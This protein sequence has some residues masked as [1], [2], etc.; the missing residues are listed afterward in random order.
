M[1]KCAIINPRAN[2]GTPTYPGNKNFML[3][4]AVPR[5]LTGTNLAVHIGRWFS[6]LLS[7]GT[8]W[9]TFGIARLAFPRSPTL[10]LL[11]MITVA[12]IPQFAFIGASVSNDPLII[13]VA[14]ATL[15]WMLVLL[16]RDST[17]PIAIK[18]WTILGLLLALA[19]IS[20][21]QGLS[22]YVLAAVVVPLLCW[23]RRDWRLF[24][25]A[26]LI[27]GISFGLIAGWWYWRNYLLYGDFFA[28]GQLLEI[29]GLRTE[30]QTWAGFWGELRGLRYSFWGLFGWFSILLPV[31]IY[32]ILDA[33]TVLAVV[34]VGLWTM[35]AV[36]RDTIE[37][38]LG[39][40]QVRVWLGLLTFAA[41]L[42]GLML[43]WLTFAISSQGRLL[44][45]GISAY[46]V[47]LVGG[48]YYLL[49]RVKLPRPV[50]VLIMLPLLLIGGSVYALTV[51]LPASYAASAPVITMPSTAKP[52]GKI[53]GDALEL[54]AVDLPTRRFRA[55]EDVPIT[56]YLRAL[57]PQ[58][59]N[60]ELFVQL[61]NQEN[62]VVGNI[63][64]QPGWGRN[65]TS[66]WQLDA[67]YAD[68]YAVTAGSNISNRSPLLA[69]VY[70]G[71]VEEVT[72]D[73]L[74]VQGDEAAPN[75]R[76]VGTVQFD[77]SG[78]QDPKLLLLDEINTR[79]SQMDG[80]VIHLTGY[81]VPTQPISDSRQPLIVTLFWQALG[82]PDADY[83][84]F[85]H[86]IDGDGN[87]VAGF[88]QPPAEG[89]FP[90]S[91]WRPGD[92]SLS[93]FTL[94]LPSDLAP[95]S[96]ELWAGL[97][98]PASPALDRLP[99][100]ASDQP[101]RDHRVRLGTIVLQ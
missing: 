26:G 100:T 94:I 41:I 67:I 47:M 72:G 10:A 36:R 81:G 32:L 35:Q 2:L 24:V 54:V 68:T 82:T 53:Y 50:S 19:A 80:E 30:S 27:L 86:L 70:V 56:L 6:L 101:V 65:P 61:L 55:G 9:F 88:D 34:G 76:T 52:V 46:G 99:I 20:K 25:Q 5:P 13:L 69:K 97:Y 43:Y 66:L 11:A 44:F 17:D 75:N 22:L 79:F 16:Q 23:Q 64:T 29:N 37:N 28:I 12:A 74:P 98:D 49:Q 33:V 57:A 31:W 59:Q 48:I 91:L 77:P 3:Y 78:P 4:S 95:G 89:R 21:L 51:L 60:Y 38:W 45:P 42:V 39:V 84:A 8:L 63:T 92:A 83:T 40:P 90:T 18:D 58:T 15:Y 73:L 1:I 87:Y 93:D 71:F 7:L 96:Y 14:T 85:V 62:Q